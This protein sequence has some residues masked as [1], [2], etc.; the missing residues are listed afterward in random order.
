ML[1]ILS[2]YRYFILD[3]SHIKNST[4]NLD[5]Y[6]EE[7][8][9]NKNAIIFFPNGAWLGNNGNKLLGGEGVKK[10]LDIEDQKV[11]KQYNEMIVPTGIDHILYRYD[12]RSMDSLKQLTEDMGVRFYHW[13]NYINKDVFKD[14]GLE[15]KYDICFWGTSNSDSY[16]FRERVKNLIKENLGNY[17]VRIIQRTENIKGEELSRIINQSW[18]TFADNV[19]HEHDRFVRKY[20][21]IPFSRSCILGNYPSR[22]KSLFEGKIVYIDDYMNDSEIKAAIDEALKNKD[23]LIKNTGELGAILTDKYNLDQ[24]EKLFHEYLDS[25]ARDVDRQV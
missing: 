16:P 10:I 19:T 24:G 2:S 17:N 1:D 9:N 6:L 13:P 8:F 20:L 25:I 7:Y 23:K 14:W 15:K 5:S 4:I 12:T 22:H 18:L 21:E 11:D 3:V